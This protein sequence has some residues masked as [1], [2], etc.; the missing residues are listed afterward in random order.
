MLFAVF[1]GKKRKLDTSTHK[2]VV[3]PM[4][5]SDVIKQINQMEAD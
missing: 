2:G 4:Q 3:V 1:C 5:V